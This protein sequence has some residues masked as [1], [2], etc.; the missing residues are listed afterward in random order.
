[1]IVC[2]HTRS[3]RARIFLVYKGPFASSLTL[4][5]ISN[6]LQRKKTCT[7]K[8]ATE[9]SVAYM[10]KGAGRPRIGGSCRPPTPCSVRN[11]L[12]TY[13]EGAGGSEGSAGGS[14]GGVFF[15]SSD[16]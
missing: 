9:L 3:A 14:E 7:H 10:L 12:L 8:T 16:K 13:A 6:F 15:N 2:A 5:S 4:C 1:M 11:K